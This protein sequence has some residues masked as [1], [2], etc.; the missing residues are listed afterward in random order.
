MLLTSIAPVVESATIIMDPVRFYVQYVVYDSYV[1]FD[2]A[3][4]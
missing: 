3:D 2:T 1:D 4:T